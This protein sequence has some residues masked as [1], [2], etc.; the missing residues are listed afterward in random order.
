MRVSKIQQFTEDE[1]FEKLFNK[2]VNTLK[3]NAF[4][5]LSR[6]LNHTSIYSFIKNKYREDCK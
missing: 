1:L 5:H 2:L 6:S 4:H 3:Y